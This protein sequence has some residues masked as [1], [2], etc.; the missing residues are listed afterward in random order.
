MNITR[1]QSIFDPQQN[2][3]G[4]TIIGAGATGSRLWLALVE[5]GLKNITIYD[6]DVVESHNLAN[7]IY[8]DAHVGVPKVTALADYY[9]HKE[10]EA[11]PPSMRFLNEKVDSNTIDMFSGTVFLLT[12]TMQS[13]RDIFE[14]H[15]VGNVSLKCVIETR[16]ASSYGNIF[17]IDP[18]DKAMREAWIDTLISDDAPGE[19]SPCGSS[20]SVGTTASIIANLAV[21]QFILQCTNP[22]AVDPRV[23]IFLQPLIVSKGLI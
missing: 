10:G 20:I 23:N 5:L 22:I 2:D 15:C 17:T 1:H 8:L 6:F 14:S 4:I 13:R 11:P 9:F 12:D 19:V 21:W 7:Q 3:H 18:N 16:M